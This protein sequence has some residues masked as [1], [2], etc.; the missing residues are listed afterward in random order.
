MVTASPAVH[1]VRLCRWPAGQRDRNVTRTM[2]GKSCCKLRRRDIRQSTE[3]EAG[4]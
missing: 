3:S 4:Q 1:L 2:H